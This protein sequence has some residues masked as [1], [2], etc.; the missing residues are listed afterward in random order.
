MPCGYCRATQESTSRL[1]SE[2]AH[3]SSG[4]LCC[5]WL[6]DAAL[7]WYVACRLQNER[8]EWGR[9]VKTLSHGNK[10]LGAVGDGNQMAAGLRAQLKEARKKLKSRTTA[11][12]L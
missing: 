5:M 12:E 2:L 3:L 9:A 4:Q 10:L 8:A 6:P 11:P 1:G 7:I